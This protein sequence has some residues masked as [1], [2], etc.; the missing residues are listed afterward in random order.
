MKRLNEQLTEAKQTPR[1][2]LV[3]SAGE[4]FWPKSVLSN[5]CWAIGVCTD[6]TKITIKNEFVKIRHVVCWSS[7]MILASGARGPG[8]EPQT[9]HAFSF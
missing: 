5:R 8:F 6:T 9:G 3:N 2:M 7:G 4:L 1:V